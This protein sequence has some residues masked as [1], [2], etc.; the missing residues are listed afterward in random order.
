[1]AYSKIVKPQVYFCLQNSKPADM[2]ESTAHVTILYFIFWRVVIL[3]D[4]IHG[5]DLEPP[6]RA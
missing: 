1:M 2:Q 4:F 3:W 6:C 5:L